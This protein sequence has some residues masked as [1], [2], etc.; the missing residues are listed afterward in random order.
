ME[1]NGWWTLTQIITD[2]CKKK[3]TRDGNHKTREELIQELITARIGVDNNRASQIFLN[4]EIDCILCSGKQKG[5][6]QTYAILTEWVP[7]KNRLYR[8][9]ALKEFALRYFTSYGPET[10]M[11][12]S[13]WSGLSSGNSKLALECYSF[14]KTKIP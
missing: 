1:L 14:H 12:F 10:V 5:G 8:D 13:W 3:T 2:I 11:D 9:E 7:I 4:S 6:K